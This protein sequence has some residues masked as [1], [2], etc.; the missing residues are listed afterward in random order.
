[1]FRRR[2]LI[3][4]LTLFALSL[5]AYAFDI[6]ANHNN[7]CVVLLHGLA[8][9]KHSMKKLDKALQT[10]G[11]ATVNYDYPS[12]S[13]SIPSLAET[14]INNALSQCPK[15]L[16][17]HFVTHSMG[18]ILVRQYLAD[19]S[20]PNLGRV[21]MLGPPNQGSEVVDKLHNLP[22]FEWIGGPSSLQ[23]GTQENSTP[24]QL[25]P[26][27]FELG[28][29]AGSRTAN[30]ILSLWLPGSDDGKVTVAN[31]KLEGM[32]QHIVLP[33]THPFMMKNRKVIA[34]VKHFLAQ[35]Q[36]ATETIQGT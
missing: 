11:Y 12:R 9:S 8:K 36:F 26:A 30:P 17:I 23:L 35:G 13:D 19:H 10:A 2:P 33:V 34:Q 14:H 4:I 25:G 16:K 20:I 5:P 6:P 31:T 22:G 3:Q 32:K 18:G 21:V 7:E 24:A 27:N 15:A 1:M 29:I 28:V